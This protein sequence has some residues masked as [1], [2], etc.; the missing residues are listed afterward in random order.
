[1]KL[2]LHDYLFKSLSDH[3]E[4]TFFKGVNQL[5]PGHFMSL[6]IDQFSQQHAHQIPWYKLPLKGP[7]ISSADAV[8]EFHE[9]FLDSVRLR[10]RSDVKIGSCLSGGLDSSSIVGSMRKIMPVGEIETITACSKHAEFD[11]YKYAEMV[12]D[13]TRANSS[14]VFPEPEKLI[15]KIDELVW[16][17]DEPFGSASI[18]AQW[19]VFEE[20]KHLGIPVM[21]DGQGADE[22]HCGYNSFLRP[23]V[24]SEL[25]NLRFHELWKI[26][27]HYVQVGQK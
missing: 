2:Q 1:M 7:K 16:H 3:S 13:S 26:Y 5:L 17:K 11:E 14:R 27:Y 23:Y 15:E 25:Y 4:Q 8:A 10:M 12:I 20:A 19:C 21:L 9:L 22:T 6:D 18:F 24:Q